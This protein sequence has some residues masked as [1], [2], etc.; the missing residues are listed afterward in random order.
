MRVARQSSAPRQMPGNASAELIWFGRSG[1]PVANTVATRAASAGVISGPGI[2]R[3]KTIGSL[4]IAVTASASINPGT[5]RP[6]NAS[7]PRRS[8]RASP[9][10]RSGFV[11]SAIQ[12]SSGSS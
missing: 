1:R 12:A 4:A 6:M 7:A 5:E 2:A 3:A 8:S 9:S 10:R 11:C